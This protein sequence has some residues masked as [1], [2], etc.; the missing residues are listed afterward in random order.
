VLCV[1]PRMFWWYLI[2]QK[3]Q[4]TRSLLPWIRS[5]LSELWECRVPGFVGYLPSWSLPTI[6]FNSC[7]PVR[8]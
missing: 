7:W 8:Q 2:W 3:R 5:I 1:V 4:V 6:H